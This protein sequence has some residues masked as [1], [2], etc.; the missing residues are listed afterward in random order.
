VAEARAAVQGEVD[1]LK[2]KSAE[3]E[4]RMEWQGKE[5]EEYKKLVEKNTKRWRRTGCSSG[6]Y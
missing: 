4:E 5:L 6:G 1:E 2:K 3:A